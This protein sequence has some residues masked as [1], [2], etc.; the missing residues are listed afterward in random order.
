MNKGK[1]TKPEKAKFNYGDIVSFWNNDNNALIDM[2]VKCI[3]RY[4]K[5]TFMYSQ[6]GS[7][8]VSEYRLFELPF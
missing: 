2:E 4:G 7:F 1:R 8:W 3:K 5:R 6:N